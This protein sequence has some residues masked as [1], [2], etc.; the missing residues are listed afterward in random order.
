MTSYKDFDDWFY[1][2]RGYSNRSDKFFNDVQ[3]PDPFEKRKVLIEWL[4]TAWKLG[5][6]STKEVKV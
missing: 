4:Q 6:E 2:E 3:C 5:H 1:E